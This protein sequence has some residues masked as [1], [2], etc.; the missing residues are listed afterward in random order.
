MAYQVRNE[1]NYRHTELGY[2]H[3]WLWTYLVVGVP[4]NINFN[5]N[6]FLQ[7]WINSDFRR[8][9]LHSAF[10]HHEK[11]GKFSGSTST[12]KQ[13]WLYSYLQVLG[14]TKI[15]KREWDCNTYQRDPQLHCYV[16]TRLKGVN[17]QENPKIR[18]LKVWCS[19]SHCKVIWLFD[20]P[21]PLPPLVG[22]N[23]PSK[24]VRTVTE[25]TCRICS[26]QSIWDY[27]SSGRHSQPTWIQ[28]MAKMPQ[29][30]SRAYV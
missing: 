21:I 7:I 3:T 6:C 1:Q 23:T 28:L 11:F 26:G 20:V 30:F 18:L 10:Q 24:I 19:E 15:F 27:F 8:K 14:M 16:H 9:I 29:I 2:G 22:C 4:E 25:G 12:Q 13:E 17:H 5:W